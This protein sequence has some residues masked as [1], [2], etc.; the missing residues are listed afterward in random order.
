[1]R[2]AASSSA[3]IRSGWMLAR[4]R[5]DVCVA[6]AQPRGRQRQAIELRGVSQQRHIAFRAHVADDTRNSV[7]DI[8]G[9]LARLVQ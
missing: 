3:A 9:G 2:A 8:F 1:M 6:D 7:I 5:L 4:R